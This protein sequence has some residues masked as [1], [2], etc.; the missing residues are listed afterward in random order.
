MNKI[1]ILTFGIF[2][3]LTS[4]ANVSKIQDENLASEWVKEYSDKLADIYNMQTLCDWNYYTNLTDYNS[5]LSVSTV[6]ITKLTRLY[7]SY[8]SVRILALPTT[9][10]KTFL[11]DCHGIIWS[12]AP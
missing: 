5:K 8:D 12:H 6:S 1:G 11:S 10:R 9:A 2:M 4:S 3:G 7:S